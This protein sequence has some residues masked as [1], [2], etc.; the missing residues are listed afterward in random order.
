MPDIGARRVCLCS[1]R[2]EYGMTESR[3]RWLVTG[4]DSGV[5]PVDAVM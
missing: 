3:G 1:V 2:L 5:A 4:I